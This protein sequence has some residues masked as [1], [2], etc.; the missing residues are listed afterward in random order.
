MEGFKSLGK[1]CAS[2][3]K[4]FIYSRRFACIRGWILGSPFVVKA[5]V[6]KNTYSDSEGSVGGSA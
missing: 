4:L 2:V 6:V 1:L 5:Y 3:A